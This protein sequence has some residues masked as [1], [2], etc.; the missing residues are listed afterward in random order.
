[1]TNGDPIG[2]ESSSIDGVRFAQFIL[3]A[4]RKGPAL[5]RSVP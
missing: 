5:L 4:M 2:Y 1:M 3:R